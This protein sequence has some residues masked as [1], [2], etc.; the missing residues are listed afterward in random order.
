MDTLRLSRRMMEG[1]KMQLF[2][3]QL[4]FIGWILLNV[5]TLGIGMLWLMPYMMTTLAAFYQDVRNEYELT[6]LNKSNY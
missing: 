2:K 3:L 4:S 1:H 5:L 6:S